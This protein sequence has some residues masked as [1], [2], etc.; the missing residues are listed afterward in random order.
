M[1]LISKVEGN[2]WKKANY[3]LILAI[4]VTLPFG[5]F[6]KI[7]SLSTILLLVASLFQFRISRRNKLIYFFVAF[8]FLHVIGVGFSSNV[9]QAFF[10]LEKKAS[11]L[12]F[13]IVFFS[14][15]NIEQRQFNHVLLSFIISC[16][17]AS[18][19]CISY[20][21]YQYKLTGTS[22][23][24]FY[25]PLT[26]IIGTHPIYLAMYICF[27]TFILVYL[28]LAQD[29]EQA[30]HKKLLFV[31]IIGYFII[32]LFLLS[33]RAEI[34]AFSIIALASIIY[35]FFQ[36]NQLMKGVRIITL[37]LIV[38]AALIYFV[39]NNLE[40]FKEAINYNGEYSI[41]KQ[42]GGRALRLLKWDCSLDI[43]KNN[44]L[45]GVGTGDAQDEL[46]K[47]YKEKNYSPLLY[48]PDMKY[49]AHNQ[50]L[51]STIDLGIPG[52][53]LLLLCLIV[54][55][56][57]ASKSK[58]YLFISFLV[59]FSICCLTESMLEVN[60]GIVFFAFFTSLFMN[61]RSKNDVRQ[62]YL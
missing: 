46:Q 21:F 35:Y 47:C 37:L 50:Y 17:I 55:L 3:L 36:R 57:E 8:Y 34:A 44:F 52:F 19:I 18:I 42:W 43:I 15:P 5:F 59:L 53:A 56:V 54:P 38:F 22:E 2:I 29:Y 24:F 27:A 6:F 12:I 20:A 48:W 13:P 58:N 11:L 7:N 10:E 33:A 61:Q 1:T 16:F 28:S 31:G 14:I 26:D 40:R 32:I 4:A 23:Y 39:P 41:D 9:E 45:F 25:F 30:K 60:K 49:N 51:Q 62:T